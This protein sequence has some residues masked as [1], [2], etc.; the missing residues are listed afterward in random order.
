MLHLSQC[1]LLNLEFIRLLTLFPTMICTK[2]SQHFE[3]SLKYTALLL[4]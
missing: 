2:V 1:I 4:S 3:N